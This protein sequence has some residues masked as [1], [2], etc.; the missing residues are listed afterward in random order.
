MPAVAEIT[1]VIL[2]GG[3]GTRMG[4]ADKGLIEYRQRPLIEWMLQAIRPQVGE[5]LISANRNVEAYAKLGCR[6]LPDTLPDFPGPLAGVL[7]AMDAVST[8]WLLVVP[9]DTPHLPTDL[10]QRLYDAAQAEGAALAVAADAERD[11]YTTMLVQTRL[12]DSLRDYLNAGQRAVHSWQQAFNP[13]RAMFTCEDL[14]NFNTRA[15][16]VGQTKDSS[17]FNLT[18]IARNAIV[19]Y[20]GDKVELP[21][22]TWVTDNAGNSG[23]WDWGGFIDKANPNV[24]NLRKQSEAKFFFEILGIE[25]V[26]DGPMHYLNLLENKTL[27]YE[28]RTFIFS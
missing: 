11:H 5:V 19:Q 20:Q 22:I 26:I 15:A 16:L 14:H 8:P 6:I 3:R 18:S 17:M 2:A 4:G 13:A 23:K 12:A 24:E 7:A 10:T 1:A 21:M 25:F 28:N 9:C 27:D